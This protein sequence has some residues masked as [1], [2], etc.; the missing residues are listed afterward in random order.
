MD[1][2]GSGLQQRVPAIP[3]L[4]SAFLGSE[5]ADAARKFP[6]PLAKSENVGVRVFSRF[7]K[8]TRT[9]PV[10]RSP[11][12]NGDVCVFFPNRR[13]RRRPRLRFAGRK[14]RR[15][16]LETE[17]SDGVCVF[18]SGNADVD[19]DGDVCVFGAGNTDAAN[20]SQRRLR[21]RGRKRRRH[22]CGRR[23]RFQYPETQTVREN[24]PSGCAA[25]ESVHC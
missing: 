3:D 23:L 11:S 5:N 24:T 17:S 8:K 6:L 7:E 16:F 22:T 10:R 2:A 18:G 4:A 21:F 19:G 25:Y 14:R 12:L 20:P 1:A 15:R 9:P 13:K